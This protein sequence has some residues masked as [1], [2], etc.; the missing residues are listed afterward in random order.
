[1]PDSCIRTGFA[2]TAPRDVGTAIVDHSLISLYS[3]L[4]PLR[5]VVILA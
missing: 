2:A 5:L 4:V 3:N 1:M